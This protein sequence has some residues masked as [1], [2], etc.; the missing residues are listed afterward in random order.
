[1]NKSICPQPAQRQFTTWL[2]ALNPEKCH[3]EAPA[4]AD[5][6]KV[7]QRRSQDDAFRIGYRIVRDGVSV[8][9]YG[10]A[11]PEAIQKRLHAWEQ[12]RVAAIEVYR[13]H[14]HGCQ[15]SSASVIVECMLERWA[16]SDD[17][18]EAVDV[19][20]QCIELPWPQ[21]RATQYRRDAHI[22]LSTLSLMWD[23]PQSQKAEV[24]IRAAQEIS[25]QKPP[26]CLIGQLPVTGFLCMSDLPSKRQIERILAGPEKSFRPGT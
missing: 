13:A 15:S 6:Y 5:Y 16:E 8:V 4:S 25:N 23:F 21:A 12:R 10:L 3:A 2:A 19:L 24:I 20:F 1:M 22:R 17:E 26:R 18:R 11:R 14:F 7:A 9:S